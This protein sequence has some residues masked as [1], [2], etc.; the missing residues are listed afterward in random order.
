VSEHTAVTASCHDSFST[1]QFEFNL[2]EMKVMTEL[3]QEDRKKGYTDTGL[4]L[5]KPV[6]SQYNFVD[7]N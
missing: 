1:P 7:E 4:I 3:D 6:I 2:Y 5:F